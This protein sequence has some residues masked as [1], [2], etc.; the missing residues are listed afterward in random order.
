MVVIFVAI[1]FAFAVLEA[2]SSIITDETVRVVVSLL[3]SGMCILGYKVPGLGYGLKFLTSAI[4]SYKVLLPI[5]TSIATSFV[6]DEKLLIVQAVGTLVGAAILTKWQVDVTEYTF[7]HTDSI[8]IYDIRSFF[9]EW[10][11]NTPCFRFPKWRIDLT[12]KKRKQVQQRVEEEHQMKLQFQQL[13]E[14]RERIE[15]LKEQFERDKREMQQKKEQE[16]IG[17]FDGCKNDEEIKARYRKLVQEYHPD[18]T[19]GNAEMFKK[20]QAEYEIRIAGR[21]N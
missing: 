9:S 11:Y 13:K 19:R 2:I 8:D 1:V 6:V 12:G 17:F 15:K 18:G 21:S 10:K 14:E 20:I 3:T 4:S 5:L 7:L 16:E